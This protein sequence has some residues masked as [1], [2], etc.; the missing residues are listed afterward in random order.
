M[1]SFLKIALLT[2]LYALPC[3]SASAQLA[4][5]YS[6]KLTRILFLVDGSGSMKENMEGKSK[7]EQAKLLIANYLDSLS[8][9]NAKTETAVRV[10]GH[11]F[12]RAATNCQDSKLEVPFGRHTAESVKMRLDAI[13]PQGWTAIAYSMEQAAKDFS[14]D[15]S[16]TNA[17]VLITD[18]LETCGGNPC[19]VAELFQKK[20]I[21][22]KPFII[23]L[24]IPQ[25][26]QKAFDCVGKYYDVTTTATFNTVM[27]TVITQALNPTTTQINL[28]NEFGSPT[29]TNIE[30]S[31]H[32]SYSGALLYNFIHA[33]N[34][35]GVPDTLK[36]NPMAK[37]DIIVHS[38]PP[39]SKKGVELVAGTHNILAVDVPQG[40]LKLTELGLYRRATPL[41]CIIR[42]KGKQEILMIQDFGTVHKYRTGV[43]DLEILT[44]PLT[45]IQDVQMRQGVVKDIPVESPGTLAITNSFGGIASIYVAGDGKMER[46]Y[47]FK[48]L[49]SK[50]SLLL[51]PGKYVLVARLNDKKNSAFTRTTNF[52]ISS[53]TVTALRL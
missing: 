46:V 40:S 50:E 3:F 41:Q 52:E 17:M 37:Y 20:R 13:T 36:L 10:F 30:V 7:F 4:D 27:E 34:D 42:E 9:V 11:Q 6:P 53:G 16:V 1:Q 32:D 28:L 5:E 39:M 49:T 43:Y 51:Q 35:A 12:P 47:E 8:R 19:A 48:K 21:S 22:L 44:L 14:G 18:G 45:K 31:L 29:E 2:T 15:A 24:G 38:V 33:L 26:K 23:G 25:D